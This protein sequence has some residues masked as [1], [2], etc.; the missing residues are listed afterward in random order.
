M[1]LLPPYVILNFTR[2]LKENPPKLSEVLN[3][4]S[5]NFKIPILQNVTDKSRIFEENLKV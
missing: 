3:I 2:K 5:V 1:I 4:K